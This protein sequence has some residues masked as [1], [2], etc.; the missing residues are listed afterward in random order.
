[1]RMNPEN[2]QKYADSF[3]PKSKILLNS[4]KAFLIGGII[5]TIGEAFITLYT[6]LGFDKEQSATLECITLIFLGA[7]LTAFH[8]Y[9]NIAKQ[10]GA[11]TV[12]PITGFSNAVTSAAM[13]FR[14]EGFVLGVGAK[15]FTI[16]GPVITYG[17]I[18]SMVA[19]L[20]YFISGAFFG[21]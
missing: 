4:I 13:E 17:V 16:A 15:I 3:A 8:V 14:S 20:Y 11:G 18:A 6:N 2:Y 7:L 1:M 5:C 12:V 10:A 19:G 9:D 21:I